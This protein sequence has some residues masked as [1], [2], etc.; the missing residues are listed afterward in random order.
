MKFLTNRLYF[1]KALKTNF[2][3]LIIF[4]FMINITLNKKVHLLSKAKNNEDSNLKSVFKS[5][6]YYLYKDLIS[7]KKSELFKTD[8]CDEI[9]LYNTIYRFNEIINF[10]TIDNKKYINNKS[11][12]YF[13]NKNQ[14]IDVLKSNKNKILVNS[15]ADEE[16]KLKNLILKRLSDLNSNKKVSHFILILYTFRMLSIDTQKIA[17]LIR[18]ISNKIDK[19]YYTCKKIQA[20]DNKPKYNISE[21]FKIY[22]IKKDTNYKVEKNYNYS[23]ERIKN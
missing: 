14:F 21:N 11:I 16:F 5:N 1:K 2:E 20:K 4:F 9:D 10:F 12:E 18:N 3:L 17:C 7:Y 6:L 13:K 22:P 23:H 15:I 19:H 8:M